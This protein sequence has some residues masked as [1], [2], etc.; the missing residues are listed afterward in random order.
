MRK[1]INWE[2][3]YAMKTKIFVSFFLLCAI[4]LVVQACNLPGP[5]PIAPPTALTN[6]GVPTILMQRPLNGSIYSTGTSIQ[7]QALVRSISSS[8]ISE[9]TFLVN[10]ASIGAA[11]EF[12]SRNWTPPQPGEYYIQSR[13]VLSD[14][15]TAVSNPARICVMSLA[16]GFSSEE[17]GY[18]GLCEIPTRIPNAASSGNI[19]INAFASPNIISYST[20]PLCSLT[21]VNLTFVARVDDPQDLVAFASLGLYLNSASGSFQFFLNWVTTKAGQSKRVSNFPH[22]RSCKFGGDS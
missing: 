3:T 6:P 4:S 21:T 22:F 17:G 13:A 12:Q 16:T 18:L 11:D 15:A 9:V 1:S 7:L 8:S 10:G 2:G 5:H 20:S 19:T 14:G